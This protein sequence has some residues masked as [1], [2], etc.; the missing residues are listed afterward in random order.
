MFGRL[1]VAGIAKIC[2]ER[3]ESAKKRTQQASAEEQ[4]QAFVSTTR[5]DEVAIAKREGIPT[6][7]DNVMGGRIFVYKQ[8]K[9]ERRSA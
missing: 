1:Q 9:K 2:S 8:G 7:I 4:L 5:G 6:R 3:L